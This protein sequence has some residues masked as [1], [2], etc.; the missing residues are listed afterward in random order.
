M[1]GGGI[2]KVKQALSEQNLHGLL[3]KASQLPLS[4][5]T[6]SENGKDIQEVQIDMHAYREL[7]KRY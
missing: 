2:K 3:H 4:T 5:L 7:H 1:Y 6:R